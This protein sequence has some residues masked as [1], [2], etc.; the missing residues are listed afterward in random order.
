MRKERFFL[1]IF[2]YAVLALFI[3]TLFI[4]DKKDISFSEELGLYPISQDVEMYVSETPSALLGLYEAYGPHYADILLEGTSQNFNITLK[5]KFDSKT[6]NEWE[7]LEEKLNGFNIEQGISQAPLNFFTE[8][9]SFN[10]QKIKKLSINSSD[11]FMMSW[12]ISG[13]ATENVKPIVLP[14]YQPF[15]WAGE[16]K[17]YILKLRNVL[18]FNPEDPPY[19]D[20]L[21]FLMDNLTSIFNLMSKG[22]VNMTYEIREVNYNETSCEHFNMFSDKYEFLTK[23]LNLTGVTGNY[24]DYYDWEIFTMY[25]SMVLSFNTSCISSQLFVGI[26]GPS[27]LSLRKEYPQIGPGA[28]MI[29]LAPPTLYEE[30]Q[31]ISFVQAFNTVSYDK[32]SLFLHELAH[33]I[34]LFHTATI[35]FGNLSKY[36]RNY[37]PMSEW[38][39]SPYASEEYTQLGHVELLIHPLDR[40]RL[41]W[42]KGGDVKTIV[43]S[44]IYEVFNADY[45]N[46]KPMI[47]QIAFQNNN[48]T[49]FVYVTVPPSTWNYLGNTRIS[50]EIR[51]QISQGVMITK[52]F[53]TFSSPV[54]LNFMVLGAHSQGTYA[55]LTGETMNLTFPQTN[56]SIELQERTGDYARVKIDFE[57]DKL[58]ELNDKLDIFISRKKHDI[59]CIE[60]DERSYANL[61]LKGIKENGKTSS[62]ELHYYNG[63]W[64][65]Y[66]TKNLLEEGIILEKSQENIDLREID[67][68][69]IK[70]SKDEYLMQWEI[71][72]LASDG[73]I[74]NH[75]IGISPSPWVGNKNYVILKTRNSQEISLEQLFGFGTSIL[76]IQNYLNNFSSIINSMSGN[77]VNFSY[78]FK[79]AKH[80]PDYN[81]SHFFDLEC[82][83]G[84]DC[85]N[86]LLK[87]ALNSVG[88][89]NENFKIDRY[90]GSFII[91]YKQM[92]DAYNQMRGLG[93]FSGQRVYTSNCSEC[94]W[95]CYMPYI[96]T[97]EWRLLH[98]FFHGIIDEPAV[99]YNSGNSNPNLI[100]ESDLWYDFQN[101]HI[102]SFAYGVMGIPETTR[103]NPLD[104]ALM[105]WINHSDIRLIT[106]SGEYEVYT[107]SNNNFA[108]EKKPSIIQIPVKRAMGDIDFVY[109]IVPNINFSNN[110]FKDKNLE[111]I[112]FYRNYFDNGILLFSYDNFH[113]NQYSTKN[114]LDYLNASFAGS[115]MPEQSVFLSWNN[116]NITITNV[117][118]EGDKAII[119]INFNRDINKKQEYLSDLTSGG[120]EIGINIQQKNIT[121]DTSIIIGE[122]E[123][124]SEAEQENPQITNNYKKDYNLSQIS[125]NL[126]FGLTILVIFGIIIGLILYKRNNFFKLARKI[127]WEFKSMGYSDYRVEEI[128]KKHGWKYKNF[129]KMKK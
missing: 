65:V 76:E 101:D 75:L 36:E 28:W 37:P 81:P 71:S 6:T 63:E 30:S 85:A 119:K 34:G 21:K 38:Q 117:R 77:S 115:I 116:T 94:E 72:G 55:L 96:E 64:I 88:I 54:A 52:G 39:K 114:N 44:G 123:E 46:N 27:G 43:Q 110:L 59:L 11:R 87:A 113:F 68:I 127:F 66:Q 128:F 82:S 86:N 92:F 93:T 104:R 118:R 83:S 14:G 58:K 5:V 125:L 26:S 108:L 78:E 74:V 25:N 122:I 105:G 48:Y 31:K 106:E 112:E 32:I 57:E 24:V 62:V 7:I 45:T 2:I 97:Q 51:Q 69:S 129:E 17:G 16:K 19:T 89:N 98:E 23:L 111:R 29:N 107:D 49:D 35:Y 70:S 8:S 60:S 126:I 100:R 73:V 120:W 47:L 10:N 22:E 42:L 3:L 4:F 79:E 41:G 20:S 61:N 84:T 99:R 33:G 91:F 1:K 50:E 12:R 67:C 18:E 109:L 103:I 90:D 102:E 53:T 40:A 15:P 95:N 124:T 9:F 121:N 56:F 80:I 13:R